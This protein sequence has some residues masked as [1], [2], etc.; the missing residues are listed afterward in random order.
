MPKHADEDGRAADLAALRAIAA[1]DRDAFAGLI[2][3]E[4]PK[5]L[6]LATGMLGSLE[7]AED[8]VQEAMI[9]LWE[10]AARWTPEARVGTWLHTVC[11][12]RSIDRLR[13]RRPSAEASA[14][15]ELPDAA[16][17]PDAAL[18]QTETVRTVREAIDQLPERQRSA[19]LLFHIQDLPQSEAAR[20]MGVS[21]SA[22]E[23]LLARARR[24]MRRML[25]AAEGEDE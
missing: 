19:V 17:L 8:V 2:D 10:H 24:Q 14:L 11:L 21:E 16:A 18:V 23:S 4:S 15:A 3:R 25:S 5:L 22:F 20:V 7:E 1:G 13:R 9:S 12:N 6:R